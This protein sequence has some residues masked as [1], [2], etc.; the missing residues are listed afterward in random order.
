MTA[1]RPS[2]DMN[3]PYGV[4]VDN[5][6][7]VYIAD[8][9]NDVVRKVAASGGTISTFAGFGVEGQGGD[10]GAAT[11][12][13]LD[14]P[15]AV[16]LDAAGNLYIADTNNNRIRKV[17]TDGIITTFAG[18][19][20]AASSGD[21]GPAT[22][23]GVEPSGGARRGQRRQPLRRGYSQPSGPEDLP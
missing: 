20:S 19:G 23:A 9:Y 11:G 15:T 1:R 21:G 7:N 8:A 6:G 12:A 5:A 16:V 13:L 14:T 18:T 4:A 2:A 22:S 17:G 3:R 10:G